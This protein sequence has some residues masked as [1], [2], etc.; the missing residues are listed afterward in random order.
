MRCQGFG[1]VSANQEVGIVQGIGQGLDR[2]GGFL[3][4]QAEYHRTP[5]TEFHVIVMQTIE[6]RLEGGLVLADVPQGFGGTAYASIF[7]S[8]SMWSR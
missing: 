5:A 2:T 1:D 4:N 3:P 8:C 7:A 6:E